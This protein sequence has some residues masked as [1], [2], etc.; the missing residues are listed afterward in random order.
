MSAAVLEHPR[1]SVSPT[2]ILLRIKWRLVANRFKNAAGLGTV[3]F[4]LLLAPVAFAVSRLTTLI[5]AESV[6]VLGPMLGA[7]TWI[8]WLVA[9][10]LMGA[11]TETIDLHR[12]SLLPLRPSQLRTGLLLAAV[13][14]IGPGLAVMGGLGF[15]IAADGPLA[16][17]IALLAVLT[18]VVMSVVTS[19]VALLALSEVLRRRR[20]QDIATLAASV[21]V[22]ALA[23][24]A[25]LMLATADGITRSAF[26]PIARIARWFPGGWSG[27]AAARAATGDL[28]TATIQLVGAIALTGIVAVSWNIA[29]RRALTVHEGALEPTRPGTS[30][31]E[32]GTERRLIGR[33]VLAKER[34]YLRRHPRYRIQ[35]VSQAIVLAIGGAPVAQAIREG[36]D[37][38][39]LFGAVPGL[40]AGLMGSNLLGADGRALWAE[41]VALASLRPLIRARSL[42]FAAIGAVGSVV[43]TIGLAA[44]LGAWHHVPPAIGAGIG[45]ALLGAGVGARVSV[46]APTT[47]PEDSNPNPFAID[48]PGTGCLN[49]LITIAG[50]VAGLILSVP[51]LTGLAF[52]RSSTGVGL[53]LAVVGPLYGAAWWFV[54]CGRATRAADR[55][56]PELI[57]EL[58]RG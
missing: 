22:A 41:S 58:S 25:Q 14:G 8:G 52:A 9:P 51:L 28:G 50:V 35:V 24:A 47:F 13:I 18:T 45:M 7:L 21:L 30:L 16:T 57:E 36:I 2:L 26:E 6:L 55:R 3:A 42:A 15:V 49:G 23:V 11:A 5:E 17:T 20:A 19:Q 12:L 53:V 37:E 44:A 54:V 32:P 39:V 34:R 33:A 43:I 46:I 4:V 40:T 10:V 56:T 48:K 31:L 38:V 29:L 27:D 1:R